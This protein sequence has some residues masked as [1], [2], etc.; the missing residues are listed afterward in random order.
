MKL[1]IEDLRYLR[2]PLIGLAITLAT[3]STLLW[4]ARAHL[5]TAARQQ[6]SAQR[7]EQLAAQQLHQARSEEEDIKARAA[8]YLALRQRALTGDEPRLDW[9]ETLETL[10]SALRLPGMSYE[11]GVQSVL[12]KSDASTYAWFGSPM[13]LRLRILH[14]GDLLDF[15]TRMT[16]DSHAIVLT[17]SCRLAPASGAAGR[18]GHDFAVLEADCDTLWLTLK[19]TPA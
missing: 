18:P 8:D 5:Q 7:A 17:R 2:L 11:F 10:Q 4:T 14:E 19:H 12:E 15:L 13:R 16:Q 3:V 1:T 6:A 9:M